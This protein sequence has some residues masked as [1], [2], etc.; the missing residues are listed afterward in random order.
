[1]TRRALVAGGL[2][3]CAAGS[4]C[5]R[6]EP[7]ALRVGEI[8]FTAAMIA[9]L[10]DADRASLADIAA[11]GVA[12]R[13]G[14]V[15]SLLAPLAARAADRSRLETLPY[16]L[17]A[18]AAGVDEARLRELYAAAPE[19]ELDVRHVVRLVGENAPLAER[20]QELQR[21]EDVRRRAL[22]GEDFAAL[23]GTYS[24]EPGAA[25]RGG[26]LEPGRRGT[27][28]DP[29]WDAAVA[30]SPGQVSPVVETIYGFHVLRLDG[31]RPVPFAEA[32]RAALLRRAV[33]PEEARVAMEGWV[34]ERPP[35]ALA[36]RAVATARAALDGAMRGAPPVMAS[37]ESGA[38][39]TATDLA[40]SWALLEAGQ[41]ES[42]SRAD[43]LTFAQWL[44]NDAREVLWAA[45]A[46]RL[47][48]PAAAGVEVEEARRLRGDA[49]RWAATFAFEPGMAEGDLLAAALRGSVDR[50]QEARIARMELQALRPL[51]R[52]SYPLVLPGDSSSTSSSSEMRKS[53][54]TG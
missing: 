45:E 6:E 16:L 53:E 49:A 28:V 34:A 38:A 50:G 29:F 33:A 36:P 8:G 15:D 19:W 14:A 41:R 48:A 21:A 17:G 40:V 24:E 46:E 47:G 43:D 32:D 13:Q 7:P 52:A 42:L 12:V 1:M 25:E 10:G 9:A 23:A 51:L 3:L 27:W 37:G 2:A 11:F 31:R 54:S 26:A 30:L 18:A 35:L 22:A 20:R 5:G 44:E 4:G 39:Y